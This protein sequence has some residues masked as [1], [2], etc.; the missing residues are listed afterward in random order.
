MVFVKN[1]SRFF[2][3]LIFTSE[4]DSSTFFE[5]VDF[6]CYISPFVNEQ[7]HK[8][9]SLISLLVADRSLFTLRDQKRYIDDIHLILS[10]D[11]NQD[12]L[13][14][15]LRIY[16]NK[17][18]VRIAWRDISGW[19]NINQTMYELSIL[20]ESFISEVSEY[21][22]NLL[23]KVKGIPLNSS[24]YEQRLIILGM[25]KLGGW[26]LNFSS[27]I[28]LIF[29]FEEDG[30]LNDSKKTSYFEF[31][32]K[33]V[34]SF[35]K[36]LDYLTEDGF[37][38][39]VDTRLR[40]FGDSG[41]LVMSFEALE[42]YYQGQ[43]REWE[44]YAMA[45]ARVLTGDISARKKLNSILTPFIYRKYLDFRAIGEIRNLKFKISQDLKLK[46]KINNIKLGPGG[47]REIEFIAQC[48]QLIR[49]GKETK[50]RERRLL[51]LLDTI[52]EIGLLPKELICKL[53]ESYCFLRLV[54]NRLQQYADKQTHLIPDN[55]IQQEILACSLGFGDWKSFNKRLDSVRSFVHEVFSQ[56]FESPQLSSDTDKFFDWTQCDVSSIYN[57]LNSLGLCHQYSIIPFIIEFQESFAIRQMSQ[58]ANIDINK[59]LTLFLKATSNLS[60]SVETFVRILKILESISGRTVYLSLLIE[61]PIAL[62]QLVKLSSSSSW[63]ASYI[64]KYPYLLDELLDPRRF[65]EPL[66]KNA[67]EAELNRLLEQQYIQDFEQLLNIMRHFKQANLLKI[68]AS[69]IINDLNITQIS[70]NLTILAESLLCF[71]LDFAWNIVVEKHGVPPEGLHSKLYGFGVIAYGKLGGNELSYSSDLDLVFLYGGINPAA[72]T[73]GPKP[74]TCS[75]FYAK[76]VTRL[77]TILSTRTL[78]GILY[79]V[80][81]RLRPSGHSGLLISSIEAYD[82]YQMNHA[83]TWEQQALVRARF[84]AGDAKIEHQ[85]NEVRKRSLSRVRDLTIVRLDVKDMREKMR[86]SLEIKNHCQFDLK[87]GHG[88]I[89]DIEFIVQ[90]GIL[91]GASENSALLESTDV[92]SQISCLQSTGFLTEAQSDQLKLSYC[93]YR[94]EINKRA[95]LELS[96]TVPVDQFADLIASVKHIWLE[97]VD[98]CNL[99]STNNNTGET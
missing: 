70:C 47:I 76:V 91:S 6:V 89:A 74:I 39:R 53:K 94:K 59:L 86:E 49:G 31:Y 61:N 50:L 87:Q 35:I 25:G 12:K 85:F 32:T 24:G 92:L 75:Q 33:V 3:D 71:A 15:Y 80:D 40:P 19:S 10:S 4:D 57:Q 55:I 79:E 67:F 5:V 13:Y 84:I 2:S 48:F 44:R 95:L 18:I 42:N 60:N 17:E 98:N 11:H 23:S 28:D 82:I 30:F 16:R 97:K 99:L 54:E 52:A 27:D 51:V 58:R 68:A 36:C 66:S 64:S 20:A 41:P 21:Y 45:K 7:I 34:Q 72:L 14:K 38:F 26:E 96:A 22:H 9:S 1:A 29:F 8:D 88:G 78:S 65:Y 43:A 56:V 77:V 37:I 69:D 81:L 73:S 93:R 62:S 46:D 83:W 63:I 90:L